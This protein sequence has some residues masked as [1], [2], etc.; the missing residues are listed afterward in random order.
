MALLLVLAVVLWWTL[1]A[2]GRRVS[3]AC[4]LYDGQRE[5]LR[6]ALVE[7][8]D[9][10]GAAAA[11]DDPALLVH[12]ENPDSTLNA[13]RRWQSTMPR[14]SEELDSDESAASTTF[15]SLTEAVAEQQRLI[16]TDVAA[17]AVE[18]LPRLEAELDDADALC[19]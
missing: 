8:E 2:D 7:V 5:P 14:V 10:A 13:L 1:G 6:G 9:A 17:S 18:H 19:D 15:A 16:E 3:A 11:A 4:D 12:L